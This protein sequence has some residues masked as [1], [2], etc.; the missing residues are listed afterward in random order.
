MKQSSKV[1]MYDKYCM[2]SGIQCVVVCVRVTTRF[3]PSPMY[4]QDSLSMQNDA[5][6]Y[7][8]IMYEMHDACNV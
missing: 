8:M 5:V 4:V 1:C 3:V 6:R 7:M 2:L